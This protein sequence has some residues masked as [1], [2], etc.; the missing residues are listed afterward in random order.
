MKYLYPNTIVQALVLLIL[1]IFATVPFFWVLYNQQLG[2]G[3]VMVALFS[4]YLF[5][6]IGT[7][8][9]ISKV[10]K[11]PLS[12]KYKLGSSSSV[13]EWIV[14]MISFQLAINIPWARLWTD[15]SVTSNVVDVPVFSWEAL[16]A[17][18]LA[19][20]GEEFV[21]RGIILRGLLSRYTP[22]KAILFTSILF[23][24]IHVSLIQIFGA[25]VLSLFFSWIFYRKGSLGLCMLLHFV[26]N[27]TVIAFQYMIYSPIDWYVISLVALAPL[28]YMLMKLFRNEQIALKL[29]G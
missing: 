11:Q 22:L 4:I 27:L 5:L 3:E 19:P 14:V 26:A 21:F 1:P 8:L 9:I 16:A 6:L 24:L 28:V 29:K 10:K 25:F 20:I 13:I 2:M 7:F 15:S 12:F 18:V 23:S 17:L